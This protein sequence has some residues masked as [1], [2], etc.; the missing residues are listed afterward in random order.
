MNARSEGLP[1]VQLMDPRYKPL[2][3]IDE[4]ALGNGH[5]NFPKRSGASGLR[6]TF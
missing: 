3:V 4:K 1:Y 2:E 5:T 6:Q